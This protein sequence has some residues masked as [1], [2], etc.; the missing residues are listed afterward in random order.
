MAIHLVSEVRVN[1]SD[2]GTPPLFWCA[3]QSWQRGAPSLRLP[4]SAWAP[5]TFL[6]PVFLSRTVVSSARAAAAQ[7]SNCSTSSPPSWSSA[8]DLRIVRKTRSCVSAEAVRW[9]SGTTRRICA[10][11]PW[12]WPALNRAPAP[13]QITQK[14]PRAARD[15]LFR[16][17]RN[18]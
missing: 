14:P 16:R 11:F 2:N 6:C 4:H 9:W 7:C 15:Q 12:T 3:F 13:G 1:R 5:A 10:D 18:G 8:S 17:R